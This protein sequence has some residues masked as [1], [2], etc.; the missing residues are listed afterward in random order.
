MAVFYTKEH[1]WVEALGDGKFKVGITAYAAEQL[2]EVVFVEQPEIDESFDAG[3]EMAVV[4]SV[5]AAS[6]IYAPV[7]GT[8][9]EV[10]ED[11]VNSPETVNDAPTEGGWFVIIKAN[12]PEDVKALMDEAA[13]NAFL[14]DLA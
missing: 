5:K 2:G 9:V 13:Y 6:D 14:A 3:A 11:I 4:E 10:N 12:N 8:I 7:A 1:E